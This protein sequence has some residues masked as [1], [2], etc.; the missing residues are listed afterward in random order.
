M[1]FTILI[2]FIILIGIIA[3]ATNTDL[4][5]NTNILLLLL[6]ALVGLN[7]NNNFNSCCSFNNQRSFI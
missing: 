6:L 3:Q 7:N 5:N 2:L 4:A 1:N